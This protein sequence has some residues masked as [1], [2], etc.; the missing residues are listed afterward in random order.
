MAGQQE[1]QPVVLLQFPAAD[2]LPGNQISVTHCLEWLGPKPKYD[3]HY[4][5]LLFGSLLNLNF[6]FKKYIEYFSFG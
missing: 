4:Q 2:K 6:F 5:L 1:R 3:H